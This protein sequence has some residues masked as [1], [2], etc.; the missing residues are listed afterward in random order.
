MNPY[1]KKWFEVLSENGHPAVLGVLQTLANQRNIPALMAFMDF[2]KKNAKTLPALYE[3]DL[4]DAQCLNVHGKSGP[5]STNY[6]RTLITPIAAHKN[7]NHGAGKDRIPD[8]LRAYAEEFLSWASPSIHKKS[9]CLLLA[10][11]YL[12]ANLQDADI[13]KKID[14]AWINMGKKTPVQ[15]LF[16][17]SLES[18]NVGAAE[19]FMGSM[20]VTDLWE[21]FSDAEHDKDKKVANALIGIFRREPHSTLDVFSLL[22]KA[23]HATGSVTMAPFRISLLSIALSIHPESVGGAEKYHEIL[24]KIQGGEAGL[25]SQQKW[26]AFLGSH[27][28]GSDEKSKSDG[29]AKQV[30]EGNIVELLALVKPQLST[31]NDKPCAN[32]GNAIENG[33]EY[34]DGYEGATR[35]KKTIECLLS[36]GHCMENVKLND[37]V[38]EGLTVHAMHHLAIAMKN[39]TGKKHIEKLVVLL[40]MGCDTKIKDNRGK[41]PQSYL[42]REQKEI[43]NHTV[44]A[45][46][47]RNTAHNLLA[48]MQANPAP[49]P[50]H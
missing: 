27:P 12:I 46:K 15:Q 5:I 4:H 20:A 28:M 30:V 11:N 22:Q 39:F 23:E 2:S 14:Q 29:I 38:M 19:H 6:F 21:I 8:D 31:E 7:G 45:H 26:L 43:W 40:D 49:W 32:I 42:D 47:A 36:M 10:C 17:R 24:A 34:F 33:F 44:S 25:Q 35:L 41:T 48:E 9:D 50:T 3:M 37:R 18:G 16:K 13:Y 1:T